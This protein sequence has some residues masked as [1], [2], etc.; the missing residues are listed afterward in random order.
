MTPERWQQIKDLL[1]TALELAPA[2]RTA[3]LDQN[4]RGD[5]SLRREVEIL[6]QREAGL[7]SRFLD[8]EDLEQV[9]AAV[10]SEEVNPWIGRRVGVY[11]IVEQIGAGGM[12]EV[13]RAFRAD[14]QYRMEVA[15]KVVRT[16]QDSARVITRFR[17]E[18][19]ILAGL[20]H[21]NIARLL[22]GGT[23]ESGAPYLVM[24][25]IEGCPIAEYCDSHKLSIPD[26]L[27]LFAQVC[28][29]VQFAHQRLI[30]HR[31]IKPTNIL[32]TSDGKPKLLDFG[33][34]KVIGPEIRSQQ[35]E[36]LTAFRILTPEYASPEQL[37]GEP[38]TTASDVYSLGVVLYDL[39]TGRSPYPA[40]ARTSQ[41]LAA[42]IS[43]REPEKPS[44]L[45]NR[46][47]DANGAAPDSAEQIAS[48][49]SCTVQ[50]L[51]KQLNGDL[52]NIVLL[53]L[54]KE[55]AR[56]YA[57][58]EQ[59]AADITRHLDGVPVLARKDT[60]GYRMS[61][62][63]GRH[64]VG[65][66]ASV[67]MVVAILGALAISLYEAHVA[68]QQSEMARAQ[69]IRAERRFNDVRNL[70]NSLMFEIHDSI[71]DLPGSTSAR[72]I[73]V[74][75]AQQYLDSLSQEAN[76][77]AALQRELAA[78]Y[79]RVGDL[80]GYDGAANLGNFSQAIQSYNKALAIR[81]AVAA[82]NPDDP[83][84]QQE[85]FN[86]Y[87][88]LSFALQNASD[89]PG[90]LS[91][92]KKALP[93]A[94]KLASTSSDPKF[95]DG[96][97]GV[98]WQMANILRKSADFANALEEYRIS[99]SMREPL[100]RAPSATAII[101]A[102][103]ASDYNGLAQMQWRTGDTEHALETSRKA[104]R[105]LEELSGA[106]PNDATLR[107]YLGEAYSFQQPILQEHRELDESLRAGRKA[108]QIFEELAK[109]D[110]SNWLA[111]ANLGSTEIGIGETLILQ[112]RIQEALPYVQRAMSL[113]ENRQ[114]K[115]PYDFAEQAESYST[116]AM[117][118]E[119]LAERD[120]S[121]S[122]KVE[123]LREARTWLQK[124]V[125]IWEQDPNRGS[126][127]PMGGREGDRVREEL[128]K[129][130]SALAKL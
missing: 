107:E 29:A 39:L 86:N 98:H 7:S 97:A 106:N 24:E 12:G 53:A 15:L 49:R 20:E 32:V 72:K 35:N 25:L 69:R 111:S 22:D 99:T 30:I 114:H 104:V 78:A 90:A 59:F 116:L 95:Q 130:N 79:N 46:V 70:A 75:R 55:P 13:Y 10:L 109:K 76:G 113:F 1:A 129:C 18:R 71:K 19:Q 36:T 110:P 51:Q 60:A 96:L 56:R 47:T 80:L 91:N 44:T 87:F 84:I 112:G 121:S 40:T 120:S 3:Y 42:A 41:E 68:R 100:A 50:K 23:T 66:I 9:A 28:G 17:N 83:K 14:D 82:A 115:S 4:C 94:Q 105:I 65:V 64:K 128:A 103:L 8:R 2:E 34:A 31:D 57:S 123:H 126:P 52:D 16:G 43:Y 73:L 54:R 26:R 21:P 101:Q 62:F 45:V 63:V 89:F 61:K 81:E 6:L 77:D 58:A 67:A 122:K 74:T 119:K 33:I 11:Q 85:L 125:Q 88:R 108:Q 27:K 48:A 117:A 93:L 38:V 5:D 124:S 102:H 92:I 127:D 118:E 37:N